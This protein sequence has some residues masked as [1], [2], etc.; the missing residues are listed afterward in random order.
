MRAHRLTESPQTYTT[1]NM[2]AAGSAVG[3]ASLGVQVCQGL[4]SYY[5]DWRSYHDD[6]A[7]ACDKVGSLERTLT[8]LRESL[9]QPFLDAKRKARVQASLISCRSSTHA[10]EKRCAKLQASAQPS[11]LR[12]KAAAVTKRALYPFKASTL[13]KVSETVNDLLDQLSLAV[14]ALHLDLSVSSHSQLADVANQVGGVTAQLGNI[15]HDLSEWRRDDQHQKIMSW[16]DA[17]DQKANHDAAR[18]KH[19]SGTG[20]WLL[21]SEKY[22]AWKASSAAHLWLHGKAG[23]GKSVLCSTIIEDLKLHCRSDMDSVLAFFYFSFSDLNN[24]SYRSLIASLVFQFC[25]DQLSYERLKSSLDDTKQAS[26][27]ILEKVLLFQITQH[28]HV[29]VVFDALDELPE[30]GDRSLVLAQLRGLSDRAKNLKTLIS[31]RVSTDI[32]DTISHMEAL[33]F[34]LSTALVNADIGRF[35]A[36]EFSQTPSLLRWSPKMQLRARETLEQ[37]ADGM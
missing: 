29:T 25:T 3:I 12:E 33:V 5:H 31:S 13:A 17:P 2:E 21:Q 19:E 27:E 22:K 14:Q 16:L 6:I 34:P 23:C 36:S 26:V 30:S 7:S 20:K 15:Q 28:C 10:L 8:L 32:E 37:K 1:V 9:N 18:Q 35:I 24:Q 11:G 4:L